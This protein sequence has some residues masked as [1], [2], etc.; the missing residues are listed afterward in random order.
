ME[1][2][3]PHIYRGGSG[4][5]N[6]Y[7]IVDDEVTLIDAG[8][9]RDWPKII[10]G[11]ERIGSSIEAVAGLIITHV[12]SDHFGAARDAVEAGVD[13]SVHEG[14][15]DRAL[16][17][18]EGRFSAEAR[19]LPIFSFRT[20]RNFFPM[21]M[22]GV[23]SLDFLDHV[24]TFADGET[25]DL[26]GQPTVIHT[27]GHTE[28]HSMFHV[29]DV[30]FTGDGLVTM[31]LLGSA[32]GPQHMQPVFDVDTDQARLSLNRI[33]GLD[34]GTILPGHGDPWVGT[35]GEAVAIARA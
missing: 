33:V 7:A 27:P 22:A 19:D 17:R 32:R 31:D 35:P 28:G 30:L 10:S 5:Y 12:H 8:C 23:L 25:I 18:Y 16:G 11:L 20:L 9:S 34:A 21:M 24:G 29:E 6:Y 2:I 15:E 13:V 1:Q 4:S 3:A 14:D 26:P